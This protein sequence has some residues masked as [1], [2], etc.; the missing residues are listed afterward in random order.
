[1]SLPTQR[2]TLVRH[3]QTDWST[4][5]RHTGRTNIPLNDT[6]RL[7]AEAAAAALRGGAW[8]LVLCSPLLRARQTCEICGFAGR[9]VIDPDCMEWNYGDVEGKTSTEWQETH[10]GWVLWRD[11][12]PGGESID[13]V[14][15]RAD[16]VA[17]RIRDSEGDVLVFAH[18]H[19][20]RILAARWIGREPQLAQNLYLTTASLSELGYER[21]WP[22]IRRWCETA[23]LPPR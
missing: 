5:G 18:G 13:E 20:L 21:E 4:A 15:A 10:P 16:R 3:G 11:G 6:G 14:A 19:F 7:Q 2:V 22:A 8:P 12:A 17:S 9:A 23:H 1:M